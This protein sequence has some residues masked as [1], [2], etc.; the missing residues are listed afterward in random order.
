MKKHLIIKNQL[1]ELSRL[2]TFITE[3]GDELSLPAQLVMN[4]NLVLEEAISNIIR[5]AYPKE[6]KQNI[7]IEASQENHLLIF[8]I[9][10]NGEEFNPTT[11]GEVDITL[12]AENRSIGGL[13][14]FLIKQIMN[15][16]EYQRIDGTNIFTL[17]KTLEK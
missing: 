13:G 2:V 8:V 1:D 17:K 4:L 3:I 9:T 10:D 5:Y 16:V 11:K 14:I 6:T 15:E 7:S 12:P